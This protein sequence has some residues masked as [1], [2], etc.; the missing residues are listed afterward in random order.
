MI[1]VVPELRDDLKATSLQRGVTMQDAVTEAIRDWLKR[2]R[3][4]KP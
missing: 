2:S 3:K 1:R 4:L